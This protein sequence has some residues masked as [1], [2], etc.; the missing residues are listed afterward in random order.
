[1]EEYLSEKEQ[2]QQI[3]NWWRENGAFVVAGLVLGV[4]GLA[5]WNYWQSYQIS[6]AE[7]AGAIYQDLTTAVNSGD[8]AAAAAALAD[9]EADYAATPYA[10]QGRLMLARLLVESGELDG[11]AGHLQAIVDSTS[12]PE[13][14]RVARI[15]L[16]RVWVAAG[17]DDRALEVLDLSRAGAFQARFHEIRGDALASRGEMRAA[18][19]EYE[20]ALQGAAEGVIDPQAVQ[21][22]MEA[23]DVPAD[24]DG[25]ERAGDA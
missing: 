23:L 19:E 10:D 11:A 8:R 13:L 7:A 21:L 4:A 12:D 16:A 14:E 3:K 5:G 24:E 17:E 6:R 20:L 9:L 22:K 25:T 18:S 2:I 15:R 1:V